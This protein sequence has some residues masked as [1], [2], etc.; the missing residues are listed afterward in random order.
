MKK[1][2]LLVALLATL[3]A[4]VAVVA[5][6]D[7]GADRPFGRGGHFGEHRGPFGDGQHFFGPNG[8]FG[9]QFRERF[10][11][12]GGRLFGNLAEQLDM[13]PEEI[14]EALQN[15]QTPADLLSEAG[16]DVEALWAERLA[17]VEGRLDDAVANGFLTQ[18]RADAIL[19]RFTERFNLI[20]NGE[21]I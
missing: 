12:R 4:G 20:H 16:I 11:E 5:A 15:G 9:Q 8:Q 18:E 17:A 2:V 3:V 14:R 7:D 6:Q 21:S 10:G 1:I 19:E 13:T